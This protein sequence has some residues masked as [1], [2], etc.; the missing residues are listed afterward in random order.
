MSS[1]IL[2]S[3]VYK[4]HFVSQQ[5]CKYSAGTLSLPQ[6]SCICCRSFRGRSDRS[7]TSIRTLLFECSLYTRAQDGSVHLFQPL[8]QPVAAPAM[9]ALER[10][11]PRHEEEEEM[12]AHCRED[13]SR[14]VRLPPPFR[15]QSTAATRQPI[16]LKLKISTH[17]DVF[18]R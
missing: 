4:C 6:D 11:G 7:E 13:W 18:Q 12:Q 17:L 15:H 16:L 3:Y 10:E 1:P 9:C 14:R 8:S 2:P 5:S